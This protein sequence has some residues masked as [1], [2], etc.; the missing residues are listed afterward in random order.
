MGHSKETQETYYNE[1]RTTKEQES[2]QGL[3]IP[4][5][6][7][8]HKPKIKITIKPK[9]KTE[10]SV[11]LSKPKI[12]IK[13]EK[14]TTEEKLKKNLPKISDDFGP[15]VVL[16]KQDGLFNLQINYKGLTKDQYTKIMDLI[17]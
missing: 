9:K 3:E 7:L 15:S 5:L 14:K 6:G 16:S 13:I 2:I 4:V 11:V 1:F 10:S 17:F 8:K 12:T